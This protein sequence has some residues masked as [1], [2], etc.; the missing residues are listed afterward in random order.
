MAFW[1]QRHFFIQTIP[2]IREGLWYND[3]PASLQVQFLTALAFPV[4]IFEFR[5]LW[6][7]TFGKGYKMI[8][9]K[10]INNS[11]F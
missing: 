8:G 5:K 1:E 3:S 4:N 11:R 2:L 10:Y 6:K 7:E 9:T